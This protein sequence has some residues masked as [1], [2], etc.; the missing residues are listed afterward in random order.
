MSTVIPQERRRPSV[1]PS[2]SVT[3]RYVFHTGGIFR[4]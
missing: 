1:S 4:K 3:F 2:L